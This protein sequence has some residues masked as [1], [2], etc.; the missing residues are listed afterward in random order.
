MI[1]IEKGLS[2]DYVTYSTTT[3]CSHL[4]GGWLNFHISHENGT[5]LQLLLKH[6]KL[7][8]FFSGWKLWINEEILNYY[9]IW[10]LMCAHVK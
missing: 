4:R 5:A 2:K 10:I 8:K 3:A 1:K 6:G 9:E 7:T